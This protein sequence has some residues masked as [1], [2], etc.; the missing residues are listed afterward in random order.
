MIDPFLNVQKH[1]LKFAMI[2]DVLSSILSK[3]EIRDAGVVDVG[4]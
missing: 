2:V 3:G 4:V 1:I